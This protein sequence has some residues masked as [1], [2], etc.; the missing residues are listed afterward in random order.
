MRC[1]FGHWIRNNENDGQS[2]ASADRCVGFDDGEVADMRLTFACVVAAVLTVSA[3][4]DAGDIQLYAAGSLRA[5]L[6]DIAQAFAAKTGHQ[7]QGKFGPS[8]LLEK[9]I[10]DGAQ[11]DVFASANMEYPRS[12]TNEAADELKLAAGQTAYAVIKASDV[13]VGID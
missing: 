6:T 2:S 9:E 5:A 13:M 3:A 1:G 10:A 4:A 8:G 7:V 12:I 11:A